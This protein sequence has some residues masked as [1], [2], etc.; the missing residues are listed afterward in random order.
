[1]SSFLL[2]LLVLILV[3]GLFTQCSNKG[4]ANAP[5][6]RANTL[7]NGSTTRPGDPA[8]IEGEDIPAYLVFK[9]DL[10]YLQTLDPPKLK[11]VFQT[12]AVELPAAAKDVVKAHW[13]E[14]IKYYYNDYFNKPKDASE[15][16]DREDKWTKYCGE[17]D[18]K[19]RDIS[20]GAPD[21]S[22]YISFEE[23]RD[24]HSYLNQAAQRV[25]DLAKSVQ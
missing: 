19:L 14:A 11:F 15:I 12:T 16:N 13:K 24:V 3:I 9:S 18:K 10:A 6:S 21:G 22:R 2:K 25:I 17:T 5:G 23:A 20:I 1:M 8:K 7:G 4:N